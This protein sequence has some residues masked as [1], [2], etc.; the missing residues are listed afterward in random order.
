[1]DN[2]HQQLTNLGGGRQPGPNT[3]AIVDACG[4]WR[5]FVPSTKAALVVQFGWGRS[6][7]SNAELDAT[8]AVSDRCR[9][10]T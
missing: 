1:V 3:G 9:T 2:L 7:A 8:S 6:S 4:P 10:R 5:V